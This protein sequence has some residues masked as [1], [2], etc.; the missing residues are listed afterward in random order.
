MYPGLFLWI[1]LCSDAIDVRIISSV[2]IGNLFYHFSEQI[3]NAW[4][5]TKSLKHNLRNMGLAT[6]PNIAI[7]VPKTKDLIPGFEREDGDQPMAVAAQ[8]KTK[9]H[10]VKGIIL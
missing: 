9:L 10:V 5:E 4:D 3:K 7:P 8:P 2:V 6:D 1:F